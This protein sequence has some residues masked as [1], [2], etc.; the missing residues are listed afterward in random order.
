MLGNTSSLGSMG[1]KGNV[2]FSTRQLHSMSLKQTKADL[3]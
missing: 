1:K 2:C 3:F